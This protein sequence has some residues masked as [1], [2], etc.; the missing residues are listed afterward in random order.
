MKEQGIE[1]ENKLLKNKLKQYEAK[2]IQLEKIKT[3][4][5][6]IYIIL[7]INIFA[8]LLISLI[9]YSFKLG[10]YFILFII[11]AFPI[12]ILSCIFFLIK[13]YSERNR[14]KSFLIKNL[15]KNYIIAKFFTENKKIISIAF[16]VKGYFLNWRNGIYIIDEKAIYT[17]EQR[18][19][20]IYYLEGIP[21]PLIFDFVTYVKKYNK[22]KDKKNVQ[23]KLGNKLDISYSSHALQKFKQDKIFSELHKTGQESYM[24][25]LIIGIFFIL[26]LVLY[27]VF[28]KGSGG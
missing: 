19:S 7:F 2:S 23:D 5:S 21:N 6:K 3:K 22:A 27:L 20:I 11:L 26:V 18:E 4:I 12:F 17:N 24:L 10:L 16:L 25:F 14:I 13:L 9:L 28:S 15:S 8:Y 1:L